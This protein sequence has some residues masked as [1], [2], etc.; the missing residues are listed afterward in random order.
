MHPSQLT[1]RILLFVFLVTDLM[2]GANPIDAASLG[3]NG[4]IAFV[5]ENVDTYGTE[6]Y[7]ASPDGANRTQ[8]TRNEDFDLSP[9]FSPDGTKIAFD[10]AAVMDQ[11]DIWVMH[12]D[13]SGQTN[14]TKS[15]SLTDSEQDPA[16]SPDGTKIAFAST[17]NSSNWQIWVM[18]ADGTGAKRLI[19]DN[20]VNAAK[21]TWSPDGTKIAFVRE[22]CSSGCSGAAE[23]YVMN[24]D[25]TGQKNLTNTA[26]V[27]ELTPN[28]SPNDNKIVYARP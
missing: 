9:T 17:Q 6:I 23:I 4:K 1:T 8:L 25:G 11:A 2:V 20:S 28:W 14:L 13:G 22:T 27:S 5:E 21:P 3:A 10:R 19:N 24:A 15:P 12:A 26:T 16:W 7:V 18:N